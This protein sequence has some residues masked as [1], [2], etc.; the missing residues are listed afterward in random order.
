[1]SNQIRAKQFLRNLAASSSSGDLESAAPEAVPDPE[2][3]AERARLGRAERETVLSTLR[4]LETGELLSPQEDFTLEAIIIPDRRPAI[5]VRDGDFEVGHPDWL[6]F[7][8]GAVKQ[9]IR[10]ALP[11]IG[12]I[13]VS[14]IPGLPFGGTGFVVGPNVLMTNRHVA[15]LFSRGI[16]RQGLTFK[17]GI[18]SA[19]DFKRE[20][21]G[22]SSGQNQ[23]S[24]GSQALKVRRILMIHPFWD[25][26]LLQVDGLRAANPPLTL[27]LATPETLLGRDVAVIGYP[28][29]DPRNATDVQ[30]Q[31]FRGVFNVKRLQ[32]GKLGKRRS[33]RSF[34]NTVAAVTHDASTLGGNSG[35]AVV[36]VASGQVVG[37]HFA[38]LYLDANFS[39][40]SWELS[41]DPRVADAGVSFGGTATPEPTVADGWWRALESLPALV[42]GGSVTSAPVVPTAAAGSGGGAKAGPALSLGDGAT[43]TIPL[44]I[45]VRLGGGSAVALAAG[46][47]TAALAEVERPVAP[48]HDVE[49]A[50]RMGYDPDFLGVEVP[51]PEALDP[52]LC[53][54]RLDGEGSRLDYHHF[55]LVMHTTRR[56]ALFTAANLD[57]SPAAKKPEPGRAYSRKALGGLGPNDTELWF[58]DP[59]I[60]DRH[61]LPD[62]FFSRDRGAFDRGHLVRREDVAWGNTYQEVQFAN[63]DTFH[64]TNCSPQ[65]AVFNQSAQ[66]V[67]NWGDLENFVSKEAGSDRLCLFAGP[68]FAASDPIFLGVDDEGPVRVQIPEQFWKVI[69]AEDAGELRAF[70][71]L[72]RQDLDAV[73]LEFAVNATW[74]PHMIAIG[75]LEELLGTL[76]FPDV[77]RAA[78]QAD[79]GSGEAVR[80]EAGI[81]LVA[82]PP[83]PAI[84]NLDGD[85]HAADLDESADPHDLALE[86]LEAPAAPLDWRAAECL[87]TLKRQVNLLAPRRSKLS[88]GVVGD[89][90]HASRSSDHNPWVVDARGRHVVTAM[91]ITHD[92]ANSCDADRLAESLRAGRDPRVKYVIWKRRMFSSYV[93]NG[94]APWTWRPY[95]GTN[96]HTKH[97]HLSVLPEQKAYDSNAPWTIA[98]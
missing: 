30:S 50:T 84:H 67:E 87:L 14:G 13:E 83:E 19:I 23:H 1:M 76:R 36:D 8:Q 79:T 85:G 56:L 10:K 25:M 52:N 17:P 46:G 92:S 34:G 77:V 69:V 53:A 82:A 98:V 65:V 26:A 86:G 39:V 41:R 81:D 55:S 61:Q 54:P 42:D 49:Y 9:A 71:F 80:A 75:A 74:K 40:P 44:E 90:A 45:T 91:D 27:S 64:T 78:D 96:P 63:G 89:A 59:R 29:F 4:K 57:A 24:S 93:Q 2:G 6:H 3:L 60:A 94:I 21:G 12:R 88:D 37:L 11:S 5:D 66:D 51:L 15:E 62:R 72:L 68:V 33:V 20:R 7:G 47:A 28:A 18:G 31:V 70:A 16:G 95:T 32:P 43:W 73:P 38:G 22:L 48:V 35:S 97:V 58:K